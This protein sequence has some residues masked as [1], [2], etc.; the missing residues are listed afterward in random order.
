VKLFEAIVPA[1]KMELT[2]S[3]A[4]QE[5]LSFVVP[6]LGDIDYFYEFKSQCLGEK[7]F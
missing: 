7:Q 5:V 2:L 4:W 1:K 3:Y 6:T